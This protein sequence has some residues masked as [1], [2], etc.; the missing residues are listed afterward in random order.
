MPS[1]TAGAPV[2]SAAASLSTARK[3][4]STGVSAGGKETPRIPHSISGGCSRSQGSAAAT[5]ANVVLELGPDGGRLFAWEVLQAEFQR[6]VVGKCRYRGQHVGDTILAAA[7]SPDH[8][9]GVD[10]R[11]AGRQQRMPLVDRPVP[12]Q[13]LDRGQD[14]GGLLDGIDGDALPAGVD[15][16]VAVGGVPGA[17]AHHHPQPLESTLDW[18]DGEVGRLDDD[19]RVRP[20]A[21]LDR[22]GRARTTRLLVHHALDEDVA[23]QADSRPAGSP[24]RRRSWRRC[25]LSYRRRRAPRSCRRRSRPQMAGRS[26]R[27]G[28]RLERRRCARSGSTSGRP[29]PPSPRNVPT[30]SGRPG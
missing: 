19:R 18:L 3:G 12:L 27:R 24:R 25:R 9:A 13:V 7:G 6:T 15:G 5:R 17:P 20:V 23:L 16:A 26:T 1:I 22:L 2:A 21:V 29:R 14:L 10:R 8:H 4:W 28:R 11:D 30:T